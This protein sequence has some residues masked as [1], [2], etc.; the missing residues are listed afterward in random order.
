MDSITQ[1]FYPVDGAAA[2][3]L[4]ALKTGDVENAYAVGS[5]LAASP[6]TSPILF[7]VLALAWWLQSPSHPLQYARHIAFVEKDA[8]SLFTSLL[9][10]P[11]DLPPLTIHVV[12]KPLPLQKAIKKRCAE[13][14]Y[15]HACKM[16]SS[17][18]QTLG[19]QAP[20]LQAM[21][22]TICKPLEAR[23]LYHACGARVAYNCA[24]PPTQ[25]WA[26]YPHGIGGRTFAIQN[27]AYATWGVKPTP[28]EA[29]RGDPRK[30]IPNHL[31]ETEDHEIELFETHFPDDIPDEWSDSEIEK[32]HRDQ[33]IEFIKNPW[34]S[35][36]YDCF[37]ES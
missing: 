5:E 8:H 37:P 16:D 22:N 26:Y 35:A 31:F 9:H 13:S 33:V 2:Q 15:T 19:I 21:K 14:L 4:Y 27:V 17:A 34:R 25:P 3:L 36:F 6:Q 11:F 28:T 10:S 23:I 1:H 30:L 32:S 18:L 12:E 7:Q 20:Y 24:P 29:L